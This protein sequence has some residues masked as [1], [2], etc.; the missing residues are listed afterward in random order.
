MKKFK[1]FLSLFLSAFVLVTVSSCS[2]D[3]DPNDGGDG[4]GSGT[5]SGFT[6]DGKETK[7]P[8]AYWFAEG[9]GSDFTNYMNVEFWSFD[10]NSGKL[11]KEYSF[12]AIYWK[13]PKDQKELETQTI[14]PDDYD[15]SAAFGLTSSMDGWYGDSY[16]NKTHPLIIEKLDN[17]KFHIYIQEVTIKGEDNHNGEQ[18]VITI[19][20]TGS[21]KYRP[22]V[23]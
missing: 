7:L 3:D 12:I 23:D 9:E 15:V 2:K 14:D 19:D 4:N 6:V 5:S 17:N 20:Y 13:V 8:Y 16:N 21:L 1:M 18:K 22:F 11:P 10:I